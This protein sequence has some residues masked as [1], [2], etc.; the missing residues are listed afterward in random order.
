MDAPT[1]E[2]TPSREHIED[3]D[4]VI[5]GDSEEVESEGE[6]VREVLTREQRAKMYEEGKGM[7]ARGNTAPALRCLLAALKHITPDTA[8]SA[9]PDCLHLV[10]CCC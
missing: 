7:H 10:C 8:F 9:L 5:D 2:T 1:N 6:E 4:A 3:A